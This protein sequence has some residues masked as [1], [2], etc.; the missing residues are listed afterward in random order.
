[1][2]LQVAIH[3]FT[4]RSQSDLEDSLLESPADQRRSPGHHMDVPVVPAVAFWVVGY[5]FRG[6]DGWKLLVAS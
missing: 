4:N 1:M 5:V 2:I 3:P 6:V